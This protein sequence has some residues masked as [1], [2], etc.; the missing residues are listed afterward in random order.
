MMHVFSL[1]IVTRE[2]SAARNTAYEEFVRQLG[3][4]EIVLVK[5]P[6]RETSAFWHR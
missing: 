5:N 6:P 4:V 1:C 2:H 3:S